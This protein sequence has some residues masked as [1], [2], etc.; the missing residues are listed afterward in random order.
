[1]T[2]TTINIG[3]M[4]ADQAEIVRK[5][6]TG[7]THMNFQVC[8]GIHPVGRDVSAS[9]EHDGTREEIIEMLMYVMSC[10]M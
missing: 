5:K 9:T 3:N 7:K 2:I 8:C 4:D 10:E 1:M 6:L